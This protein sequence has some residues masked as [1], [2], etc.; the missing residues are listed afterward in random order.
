M[1]GQQITSRSATLLEDKEYKHLV[2]RL[3]LQVDERLR[4]SMRLCRNIVME[5]L[6]LPLQFTYSEEMN[7]LSMGIVEVTKAVPYDQPLETFKQEV[8]ASLRSNSKLASY[9]ILLF[10]AYRREYWLLELGG[11]G[12]IVNRFNPLEMVE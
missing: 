11:M 3:R 10:A 5:S 7:D 9:E 2:C 6:C 8:E 1:K 4:F 12:T